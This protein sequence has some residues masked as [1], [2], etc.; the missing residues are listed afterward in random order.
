MSH[1]S[2]WKYFYIYLYER[3]IEREKEGARAVQ[4][5]TAGESSPICWYM[6]QMS[7][8]TYPAQTRSQKLHANLSY[9]WQRLNYLRH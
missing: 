9:G 1:I 7:F 2:S 6:P 3:Q 4:S 8:R 5:E